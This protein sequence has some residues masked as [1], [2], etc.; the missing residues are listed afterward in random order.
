MWPLAIMKS[1]E[2]FRMW[3]LKSAIGLPISLINHA[4]NS[5]PFL[6]S[7]WYTFSSRLGILY[8]RSFTFLDTPFDC[9]CA[10]DIHFSREIPMAW[11]LTR[12]LCFR[13]QIFP[14]F[15]HLWLSSMIISIYF[16]FVFVYRWSFV[17]QILR[18]SFM[19]NSKRF[20]LF[21]FFKSVRVDF[22]FLYL[23]VCLSF[24]FFPLLSKY[25]KKK[26]QTLTCT[27]NAVNHPWN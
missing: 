1:I 16:Y 20:F 7:L 9:V 26:E 17:N 5:I 22:F 25:C 24:P 8:A 27:F 11:A 23:S 15:F 4:A 18:V 12:Q 14:S 19:P 6:L 3:I 21:L 13:F 10:F 2:K